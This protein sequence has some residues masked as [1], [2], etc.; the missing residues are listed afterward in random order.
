MGRGG[1]LGKSV[2]LQG[3]TS[4]GSVRVPGGVVGRGAEPS[5]HVGR[6]GRG[7]QIWDSCDGPGVGDW[8]HRLEAK[9]EGA[10]ASGEHVHSGYR[11]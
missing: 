8:R 1:F 3:H 6:R 4:P 2:Y 10:G 5:H 9:R 11:A 7:S